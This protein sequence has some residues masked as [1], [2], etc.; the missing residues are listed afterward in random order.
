MGI[1][2]VTVQADLEGQPVRGALEG[3]DAPYDPN[4]HADGRLAFFTTGKFWDDWKLTASADTREEPIEDLFDDF[5]NKTPDSLFRRIDPDYHYPTFGDDGTVEETAP[6]SGKFFVKV[7]QREN[8]AMWGNFKVGY[9]D[10]ELVQ[11]DRGL[12]GGNVHYQTLATTRHGEQRL[13]LDGFAAEPGTVPSREEFRGTD[14]SLYF[15]RRQDIL[16]GLRAAARRGARQGLAARD[17]RGPPAADRRLRH[18]LSPG[19]HPAHRAALVDR[20]RPACSCAATAS[21]ATRRW[22]VVQYEY[23]P[24]FDELDALAAGGTG[25]SG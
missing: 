9:L 2:D 17:G 21:P 10:N 16:L 18:R 13:A 23:T 11:V 4:S 24:G 12:Y 1:A 20:G 19:P 22:L 8:H 6:T 7:D 25:H 14:G 3:D 15:L 5:V